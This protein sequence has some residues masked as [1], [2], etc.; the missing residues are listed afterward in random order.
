MKAYGIF[1][2]VVEVS[3]SL[4]LWIGLSALGVFDLPFKA[5][6]FINH[7]LFRLV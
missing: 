5:V 2:L 6:A 1:V 7:K 3:S 4:G